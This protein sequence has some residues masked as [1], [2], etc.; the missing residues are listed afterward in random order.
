[1]NPKDPTCENVIKTS[2]KKSSKCLT[3]IGTN[4]AP[5][6]WTV[7]EI[8]VGVLSANLPSM[9]PLFSRVPFKS[10]TH[11]SAEIHRISRN[12]PSSVPLVEVHNKGSARMK[13]DQPPNSSNDFLKTEPERS[14]LRVSTLAETDVLHGIS[15]T[16]DMEQWS[17]PRKGGDMEA[18]LDIPVNAW[19]APTVISGH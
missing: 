11:D 15:V 3:S 5:E 1:M 8:Q 7:V 17:S 2:F 16:T 19:Q 18:M 10:S 9:R 14:D 12:T 13:E 6:I 4:V